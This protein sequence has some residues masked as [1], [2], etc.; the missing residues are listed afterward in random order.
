MEGEPVGRTVG[1]GG[2][3]A[4]DGAQWMVVC[5]EIIRVDSSLHT[6]G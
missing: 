6:R 5:D 1:P 4:C 2:W 3:D